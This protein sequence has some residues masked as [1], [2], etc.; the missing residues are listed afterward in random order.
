MSKRGFWG[1]FFLVVIG[2]CGCA[3][4]PSANRL[5]PRPL[6]APSPAYPA[7]A[8]VAKF[9]GRVEMEVLVDDYGATSQVRV[10]KEEP[11]GSGFGKAAADAVQS[12]LWEP[13]RIDG[14]YVGSGMK[15]V[16]NFDPTKVASAPALPILKSRTDPLRPSLLSPGRPGMALLSVS[17]QEDGSAGSVLV[18]REE[19]KGCGIAGAAER[20]VREWRWS[21]G[22]PARIYVLIRFGPS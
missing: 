19:P 16:I 4:G 17:V 2:T 11:S 13:A 10:K 7:E 20:C 9:A 3:V 5:E 1:A 15:V 14:A 8:L 21:K 18:Y 22:S 6:Y 12:W